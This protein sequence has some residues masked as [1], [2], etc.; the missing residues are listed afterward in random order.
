MRRL[1]NHRL[2]RFLIHRLTL[3][4]RSPLNQGDKLFRLALCLLPF[5]VASIDRG[6]ESEPEAQGFG[7]RHDIGKARRGVMAGEDSLD[8][9]PRDTAPLRK[10]LV[11]QAELSASVIQI[12]QQNGV[13]EHISSSPI[14]PHASLD[15][16]NNIA[17]DSIAIQFYIAYDT[18][19]GNDLEAR[20]NS[21]HINSSVFERTQT[22][23][24]G[25]LDDLDL[26]LK[27]LN[28]VIGAN[29]CGKTSLQAMPDNDC[30]VNLGG[31]P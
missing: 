13:I 24:F 27:P 9:R 30:S 11:A 21:G 16:Q 8:R 15:S 12:F 26:K 19:R 14:K 2:D 28:V 5:Q 31:A 7:D 17:C 6:I 22:Q 1:L 29:C 18:K 10:Q 23:G 3:K 25:G 20:I 4:T